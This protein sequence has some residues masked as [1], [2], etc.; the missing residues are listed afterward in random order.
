MANIFKFINGKLEITATTDKDVTVESRESLKKFIEEYTRLF[1][2]LDASIGLELF[3]KGNKNTLL[4]KKLNNLGTLWGAG[5]DKFHIAYCSLFL[6]AED[7]AIV[8][9][10]NPYCFKKFKRE[11]IKQKS[12]VSWE[13]FRF[14]V[15]VCASF[16]KKN[17]KIIN[18]ESPDFNITHNNQMTYIEAAIS[19]VDQQKKKSHLYKIQSV[20]KKKNKK[21]YA[22]SNTALFV[23]ATNILHHDSKV[24]NYSGFN[25]LI[26]SIEK[27]E[28]VKYGAIILF[29]FL[30]NKE[31][32][33]YESLYR[34]VLFK[35]CSDNLR[36]LIEQEYPAGH[37]FR[38]KPEIA[39]SC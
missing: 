1:H 23:D 22:N 3:F 34:R 20:I 38:E 32:S 15:R 39:Q 13:G 21:H 5:S 11:L 31:K 19:R 18:Q 27:D 37:D 28:D 9:A 4:A 6:L 24:M 29:C 2:S 8:K 14:E 35:H 36:D 30:I 12:S 7:L 10:S 25:E 26:E 16:I 17:I 33:R